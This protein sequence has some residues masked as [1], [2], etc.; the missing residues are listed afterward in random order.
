MRFTREFD[1]E[2]IK[3]IIAPLVYEVAEDGVNP[4]NWINSI[5]TSDDYWIKIETDENKLI[6][7]AHFSPMTQTCVEFHPY[8]IKEM[9]YHA[10]EIAT[11][12][13]RWFRLEMPEHFLSVY[14]HTP[15]FHKNVTGFLKKF[16]F[17]KIGEI[18]SAFFKDKQLWNVEQYQWFR[19]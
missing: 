17:E 9:R 19:G 18:K 2:F 13:E 4:I 1:A 8:F 14:T 15:A 6:G 16:N 5:N 10:K 7:F 3:P 11:E 12:G